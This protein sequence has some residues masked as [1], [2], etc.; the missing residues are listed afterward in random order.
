MAIGR[1]HKYPAAER[2]EERLGF[3]FQDFDIERSLLVFTETAPFTPFYAPN[4]NLFSSA[5][6]WLYDVRNRRYVFDDKLP[7]PGGEIHVMFLPAEFAHA[8]YMLWSKKVD[9]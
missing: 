6:V 2:V 8:S 3:D 5:K 7:R 4:F 9:D 1:S